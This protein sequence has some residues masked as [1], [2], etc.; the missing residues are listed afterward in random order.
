MFIHLVALQ[1][2]VVKELMRNM[3]KGIKTTMCAEH[4]K[5]KLK[6]LYL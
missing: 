5:L 3:L 2:T 6:E 1:S 4:L